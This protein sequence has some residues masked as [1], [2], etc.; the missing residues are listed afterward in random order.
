VVKEVAVYVTLEGLLILSGI[1]H[2]KRLLSENE[3]IASGVIK[4][5]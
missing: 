1:R 5:R 2:I 4:C 3:N